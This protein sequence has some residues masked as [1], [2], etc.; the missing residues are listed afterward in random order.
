MHI[1][2][3]GHTTEADNGGASCKHAAAASMCTVA[4]SVDPA[5]SIASLYVNDALSQNTTFNASNSSGLD[6]TIGGSG[7]SVIPMSASFVP[8]LSAQSMLASDQRPNE[9][10]WPLTDV[11]GASVQVSQPSNTTC[12]PPAPSGSVIGE[13]TIVS[14]TPL[15]FK[16]VLSK[17]VPSSG[18]I[19]GG[20]L[21]TVPQVARFLVSHRA[22]PFVFY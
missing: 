1:S 18:L 7:F 22:S 9:Y 12:C 4:L 20:L 6:F 16:A 19:S 8:D 3:V 2:Y 17:V 13:P 5:Q 14:T 15:S 11:S 21:V 10:V